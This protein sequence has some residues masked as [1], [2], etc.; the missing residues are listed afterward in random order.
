MRGRRLI[1]AAAVALLLPGCGSPARPARAHRSPEPSAPAAASTSVATP[2]STPA[3]GPASTDA[4]HRG[5]VTYCALNPAVTQA[6]IRRTIC[7]SGWTATVRPPESYTESLKR[8][9]IAAEGLSGG[10]SAYEEDH[11][12]P[13][14]LGGAPSAPANLSPEY[15]RSP[16]RKDSSETE[17]KDAVCAGRMT[18]LQAQRR[19]A[20]EWLAAYPRY[21]SPPAPTA[22][23]SATPSAGR[24]G[25]PPN[26]WGYNFCGGTPVYGA[27]SSFCDY[28]DCI[29]SFWVNTKGYVTECEDGTYS[30]SGGREGVCSYHGGELR[31]LDG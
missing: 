31:P 26:P 15:P 1:G 4:C 20:T 19:L 25:A 9:Q 14:E 24:C 7:L 13:L 3:A 22:S 29:A 21:R 17:L 8:E 16:N 5:G 18:L 10:L 30:H 28:F 23:A 6:T 2:S 11:R 12:M 27:P